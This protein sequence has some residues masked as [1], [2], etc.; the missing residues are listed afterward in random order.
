MTNEPEYTDL[1][2]DLKAFENPRNRKLLNRIREYE[3][4][5]LTGRK[6]LRRLRN[7]G[8]HIADR[9][10]WQIRRTAKSF[11]AEAVRLNR[12]RRGYVPKREQI[13][14]SYF[15]ARRWYNW[16]VEI[17]GRDRA[18][19]VLVDHVTVTSNRPLSRGAVLDR[20]REIVFDELE[21]YKFDP[22]RK[23][24]FKLVEVY[25]AASLR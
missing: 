20:A 6:M 2:G 5:G 19:A 13:P 1:E 25:R 9:Q 12:T 7:E 4:Q 14:Q 3:G 21:L 24:T 11:R 15:K 22:E 17:K 10:F 16:I 18:G 23:I 8:L